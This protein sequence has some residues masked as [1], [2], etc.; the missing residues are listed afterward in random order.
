VQAAYHPF[1]LV[2]LHFLIWKKKKKKKNGGKKVG[3][4]SAAFNPAH[5]TTPHHT[6]PKSA[7]LPFNFIYE[8]ITTYKTN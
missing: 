3:R 5:H 4:S 2:Q 7:S 8:L 1:P 6:T